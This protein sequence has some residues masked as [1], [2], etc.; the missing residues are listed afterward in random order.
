MPETG[1]PRNSCRELR[2]EVFVVSKAD[3]ID[4]TRSDPP[5][6]KHRQAIPSPQHAPKA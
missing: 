4:L 2:N 6:A 5:E 1:H 3:A